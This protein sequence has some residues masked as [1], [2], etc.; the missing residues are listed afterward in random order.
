MIITLV[1]AVNHLTQDRIEFKVPRQITRCS[2]LLR[3]LLDDLDNVEHTP[4]PNVNSSILALIIEYMTLD[5]SATEGDDRWQDQFILRNQ[6][7]L[8]EIIAAANYL[9]IKPLVDA[10]C[11]KVAGM[12][13][14]RTPQELGLLFGQQ[15]ISEEEE[16]SIRRN[17][18]WALDN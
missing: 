8:F 15:P 13:V 14:G 9:D 12:L 3:H 4:L 17:T 18:Q 11:K 10:G 7:Q 5:S 1:S 2:V 6:D 16:E